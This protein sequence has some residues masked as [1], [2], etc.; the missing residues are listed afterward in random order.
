MAKADGM[1]LP[2]VWEGLPITLLECLAVGCIPICSP[3][4]G[5]VDVITDGKNGLLS[6]SSCEEDYY[7]TMLRFLKQSRE[8]T[9][10][11]K[12]WCVT[13]FQ[14]YHISNSVRKYLLEYSK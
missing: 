8:D 12:Q 9:V 4:G 1:C 2:S 6:K 14:P 7:Q 3:V 13:S 5:V 11:M 10:R